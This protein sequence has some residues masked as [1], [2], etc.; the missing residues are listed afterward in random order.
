M[1]KNEKKEIAEKALSLL[2]KEL[3]KGVSRY[4]IAKDTGI[5][6][7]TIGNYIKGDT[8]PTLANANI[9][10]K[11]FIGDKSNVNQIIKS[12]NSHIL[13]DNSKV[14]ISDCESKLAVAE[15]EIEYLK[16]RLEDKEEII[17]MLKGQMKK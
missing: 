8:L 13:G 17:E 4:K 1:K 16:Q 3:D 15:R 6:E 2:K 12:K 9:L 11:Y 10:L 7:Q 5:T 14:I